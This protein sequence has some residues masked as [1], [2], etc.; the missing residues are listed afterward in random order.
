M[1]IPKHK[2]PGGKNRVARAPYNFVP[3]PDKI[4]TIDDASS[5]PLHDRYDPNLL[6]GRLS[7]RLTTAS[8]LYVRAAQKLEE[9]R[10]GD[11]GEPPSEFFYGETEETLLIPG[12][13]LRGMLRTM[14]EVISQSRLA[15]VTD[16]KLFYR[17]MES[18]SMGD[19][20]RGRMKD[21]VRA[22]FYHNNGNL[23]PVGT[24]FLLYF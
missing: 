10:K 9:Y 20:Y 19:A 15:P 8:P 18:T 16:K 6:T 21:K 7:C 24:N 22:G 14:V 11:K 2:D 3:L 1:S 23:Y 17:S 13:S 4:L 5:Q 12:S